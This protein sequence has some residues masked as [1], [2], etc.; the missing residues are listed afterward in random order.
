MEVSNVYVI[1]AKDQD[2]RQSTAYPLSMQGSKQAAVSNVSFIRAWVRVGSNQMCI[3]YPRKGQGRWKLVAYLLLRQGS[4]R[5]ATSSISVT[6][7]R[8]QQD[9]KHAVIRT[10]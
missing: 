3:C 2:R 9:T 6:R 4:G 7:A 1:Q 5:A 8:D 10:G